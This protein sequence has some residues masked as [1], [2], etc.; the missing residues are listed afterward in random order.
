MKRIS[1]LVLARS[2]LVGLL[3]VV[4]LLAG[5]GAAA[6]LVPNVSEQNAYPGMASYEANKE[7]R[8][9]YGT[10]GYERPFLPVVRLPEGATADDP[11][12]REAV[13][14]MFAAAAE[15]TGGRVVSYPDTGDRGF[16]GDAGR[17]VFGLVY[18]GP[19]EQGGLPGSALG[20]GAG[21]DGVLTE[22][23][24]PHLPPGAELYVTGLDPLAT[25]EDA[26]GL[27]VP[28]K[29]LI[30]IA[31]AIV[32][33]GW[34]FRSALA[35]VP[36]L[37][38]LVAIPASF[39]GLLVASAVIEVHETTLIMLPLFGV[40]IAIDYALILVARWREERALG[41][42]GDEA[43]H[44]AMATSGH[45]IVFSS[46]AVAIGLVTMMVLPIPLLRSLGVGGTMVTLASALVSLTLLPLVLARAGRRL[47]LKRLA[48]RDPDAREASAS[49][50]WTRWARGVVRFRALTAVLAGGV[51]LVLTVIATGV[52]LNMPVSGNLAESGPG[53]EGL[54]V[55]Q[56]GGVPSGVLTSFDVYVPPGTDPEAVAGELRGLPGVHTVAAPDGED[57]RQDGSAL[58]TVV[59]VDEGGS[60][61]GRDTIER[62]IDTVPDEVMVGGNATQQIDYLRVTYGAFPWM[63][64]LL[65][66]VTYVMLARA[67][68]SLLLP[69]KAILLN[70]LSLGAVIGAMVILWQWGW[71]TQALL[72]IQPDGAIGTFVPVTIFAFLYGLSMDYEVFILAR[73]REQYDRSGNTHDAVVTGVARTGRLVTC[74][75]LVLFFS[76]ASMSATGELDVAI[77]ASGI[78]LGI[79]LDAT[80]IR[81][82]LVPATVA[83]MGKWNWW[84][85]DR[86]ARLLRVEPSPLREE[87]PAADPDGP[88]DGAGGPPDGARPRHK[89][90]TRLP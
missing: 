49:R 90:V 54:T 89:E 62:V 37:I 65:A 63:L 42:S 9:R 6:L 2:R 20:E 85:P 24:T 10:G 45:A 70:L 14:E 60:A 17:T 38:A 18:G 86:A 88:A 59:P 67:F 75:A 53:R 21:L 78:A 7:I 39:L 82:L 34:V 77:F 46:A 13:G 31:A 84:L 48:G 40:G 71:G 3:T 8:E 66:L 36:L 72:G 79:L 51:L 19:V 29:L 47:D 30:T 27:N 33:M 56:D 4:L 11:A 16:V 74:A 15:A 44:R 22:V 73:M 61:A 25:G 1:Q 35:L 57:W 81:S 87:R 12:V 23:M 41:H 52:N 64:A 26:G 83:M 69:L 43:V 76:F 32:V 50:M 5:G 55:L 68:R 28:V 80:V 58:V